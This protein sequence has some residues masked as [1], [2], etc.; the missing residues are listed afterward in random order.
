MLN[1]VLSVAAGLTVPVPVAVIVTSV[2]LPP[3][4]L[5]IIVA[6]VVPHV[7]PTLLLSV[8]VGPPTH[9]PDVSIEINKKRVTKRKTLVIF[10]YIRFIEDRTILWYKGSTIIKKS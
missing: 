7:L 10:Y 4:V 1:G 3:N 6:G 8:T 5:P 2:A 9:C